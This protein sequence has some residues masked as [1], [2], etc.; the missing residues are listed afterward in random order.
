MSYDKIR[1]ELNEY[2]FGKLPD[3]AENMRKAAFERLDAYAEEHPDYNSYKLKA[4]QYEVITDLIEPVLFDDIPFFYETGAL[5]AFSDGRYSRGATHANGWLYMRNEHLFKDADPYAYKLYKAHQ[6]CGLYV[7]CG[8]YT[9]LMH[10][11]LPLEKVFKVGLKGVLEELKEAEKTCTTEQETDFILTAKTGIEC[12]CALA[13]KFAKAAKDKGLFEIAKLASNVPFNPPKT[14]HEGLCVLCFMRKVL[15]SL[16]G[17][18]FSSFGRV[19]VLL[20]PLYEND[21]KC[22]VSEDTLLDLITKFLLIFDCTMN[23]EEKFEKGFEYELENTLTLGGQDQNGNEVF[24]GITKLF[25]KARDNQDIIYPKMMVRYSEKSSDEYLKTVSDN[26]VKGKSL[27]LFANDDALIPALISSG[28]E[29]SDAYDYSVGGC[30]DILLPNVYIHNSGEYF[31]IATPLIWSIY[32]MT[33]RMQKCEIF[34]ENLEDVPTFDEFYKRYLSG[35]RRIA[36]QKAGLQS[37]GVKVWHEVNPACA[38]SALMQPCIPKKKDITAG[39]GKY[40]KETAYLVY[41]PETVDSL[42]TIKEL[43]YEQKICTVKE[44]FDQCRNDWSNEELRQKA[45]NTSSHGDGS[46]KSAEFLGKFIDDIYDIFEDL[47]TAY[48][49]KFRLGSNHYTEIVYQRNWF[50]SM[51]NGRRKGDFLSAGLTPVRSKKQTSLFNALDSL[52]FVDTNKLAA[53]ASMTLTLPAGKMDA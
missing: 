27:S 34:F 47:P 44:L 7:Q 13:D 14:V 51:P 16:E 22:G 32:N 11:G 21:I 9:D 40:S 8:T 33:E 45:F 43:C 26:L 53:N 49:G 50:W 31:S 3:L 6:S 24:N 28:M 15:G 18:G 39:S 19:D 29:S 5:V 20:A 23:R 25:I 52:R 38:M 17:V 30:W 36:L 46:K 1:K 4:K 12:L 35:I 41:L 42:L 10:M 2:Y 48:G 37:R